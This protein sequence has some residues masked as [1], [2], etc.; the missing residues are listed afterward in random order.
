MEKQNRLF[1]S[2][3][4]YLKEKYGTSAYRVAVAAGFSCPNRN[5]DRTGGCTYCD[6]LGA[7]AVYQRGQEAD[8]AHSGNSPVIDKIK[9]LNLYSQSLDSDMASRK[10]RI[11]EQVEN[12]IKFLKRRYDPEYLLLYF[13]AFS[14]T[15]APVSELKQIYDFSLALADFKELIVSTRPDCIS[16]SNIKLLSSY[17]EKGID[18]WVELGLQTSNNR[19]LTRINRGH[20]SSDFLKAY[21]LL[22]SNGI[23]T[24]VH[25]IFGLPGEGYN[26]IMESIKFLA[27]LKPEGVKIH[28]LHIPIG[29]E[30]FSEYVMGELIVPSGLRHLEYTIEAIEKLPPDTIIHRLTCDTPSH[31][32]GA[33]RTFFKK[34]SFYNLLIKEME[35]RGSWQGRLFASNVKASD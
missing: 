28:N 31:R 13:Q 24:T 8:L 32:L 35:L 33:P 34:G 9:K 3:S 5:S 4:S 21:N 19:S 30:M 14:N 15:F 11:K 12:S 25:L 6:E 20:S 22:K 29:T 17:Q 2:Y 1:Y 26:E 16:K 18:V 27:D 10:S 7:M 23:K